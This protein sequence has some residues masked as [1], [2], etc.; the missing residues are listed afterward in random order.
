MKQHG[1][2]SMLCHTLEC[3]V[4]FSRLFLLTPEMKG[5]KA[6]LLGQ[7]LQFALGVLC[8]FMWVGATS[9]TGSQIACFVS[10]SSTKSLQQ[11]PCSLVWRYHKVI[12]CNCVCQMKANL[13]LHKLLLLFVAEGYWSQICLSHLFPVIQA[14]GNR[15]GLTWWGKWVRWP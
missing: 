8:H 14:A 13:H 4:W 12:H 7:W 10:N 6:C 2:I 15:S 11:L 1:L 3:W 9:A 5:N